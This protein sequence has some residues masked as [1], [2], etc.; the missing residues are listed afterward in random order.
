MIIL[1]ALDL[2]V[3]VV[4][5]LGVVAFYP[6]VRF[7]AALGFGFFGFIFF[8]HGQPDLLHRS[9]RG[10]AWALLL[11]CL[12]QLFPRDSLCPAWQLL[13]LLSSAG[14]CFPSLVN[15]VRALLVVML[16]LAERWR[17]FKRVYQKEIWQPGQLRQVFAP[18]LP[19]RSPARYLDHLDRLQRDE[20]R[21]SRGR[22]EFQ[23]VVGLGTAGGDHRA[24]RRFYA[25]S[26]RSYAR[27]QQTWT[28]YQLR[29][30][31]SSASSPYRPASR[32]LQEET[33][34]AGDA[35][36]SAK[37]EKTDTPPPPPQIQ[38]ADTPEGQPPPR[39]G[40]GQP[41]VGRAAEQFHLGRALRIRWCNGLRHVHPDRPAA[42]QDS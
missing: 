15:G 9:C 27:G 4:L 20:R 26:K 21:E 35:A 39:T 29:R 3:A 18:R 8:T 32:R 40:S 22:T 17:T 11:Y 7:R 12:R 30:A 42:L 13:D 1:G 41:P 25:G 31:P 23:L 10:F 28:A 6:L 5:G 37:E 14:S 24:D 34:K 16:R 38:A 36:E 19:V 33:A 2:F